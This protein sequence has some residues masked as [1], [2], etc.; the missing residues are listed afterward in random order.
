MCSDP[1]PWILLANKHYLRKVPV[2]N[3]RQSELVAR[4]YENIQQLDVHI[5]KG[6]IYFADSGKQRVYRTRIADI[7][8]NAPPKH[9]VIMQHNVF[10]IEGIAVDWIAN[11]LYFLSSQ[12]KTL[13]V[14]ALNG[15]MCTPLKNGKVCQHSWVCTTRDCRHKAV[16][17]VAVLSA[18]IARCLAGQGLFVLLRMESGTVRWPYGHG[19]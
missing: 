3:G 11:T 19:R 10:G 8:P 5:P 17:S 6:E 9:E 14:C 1:A 13:R 7:D 12:E 4:G 15:T 2:E 16:R 18:Q